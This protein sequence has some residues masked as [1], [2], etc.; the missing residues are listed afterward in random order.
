MKSPRKVYEASG[1]S[2]ISTWGMLPT[3]CMAAHNNL[4]SGAHVVQ[5]LPYFAIQTFLKN[6]GSLHNYVHDVH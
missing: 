4:V 3:M 2:E 5:F 1:T 6:F